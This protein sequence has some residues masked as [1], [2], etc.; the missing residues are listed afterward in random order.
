MKRET[1]GK[2]GAD[3][4]EFPRPLDAGN[5]TGRFMRHV[6]KA[7]ETSEQVSITHHTWIHSSPSNE[8][9]SRQITER[10]ETHHRHSRREPWAVGLPSPVAE[11]KPAAGSWKGPPGHR[12]PRQPSHLI[13]VPPGHTGPLVEAGQGQL[14]SRMNCTNRIPFSGQ[15][16]RGHGSVQTEPGPLGRNAPT[17][18][19]Q[20]LRGVRC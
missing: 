15:L 6:T 4:R 2:L 14:S 13:R 11:G 8:K 5:G 3:L 19:S 20:L 17:L 10:T 9:G 1:P 16:P 12:A 18:V 7:V